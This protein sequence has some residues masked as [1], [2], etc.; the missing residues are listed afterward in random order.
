[1]HANESIVESRCRCIF[2]RA[3][4]RSRRRVPHELGR[5]D[6]SERRRERRQHA[7]V[8]AQGAVG[9]PRAMLDVAPE[10]GLHGAREPRAVLEEPLW[11]KCK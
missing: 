9:A 4:F 3:C 7:E 1:M 10:E 5:L 8:G 2:R 11:Q 6:R